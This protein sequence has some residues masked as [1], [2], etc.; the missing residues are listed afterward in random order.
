MMSSS[1]PLAAASARLR[2][3]PGRPSTRP[4][5]VPKEPIVTAAVGTLQPRLLD[6]PGLAAYLSISQWSARDLVSRGVIPRLSIPLGSKDFR[7]VVVDRQSVDVLLER[8]REP[9]S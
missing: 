3:K 7:R 2:G 5:V 1:P 4:A 6:I 8:W 9:A